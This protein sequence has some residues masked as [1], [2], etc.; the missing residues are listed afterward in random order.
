MGEDQNQIGEL[1]E[2]RLVALLQG[3]GW[4]FWGENRD[5]PCTIRNHQDT[6]SHGVDAYMSYEDPYLKNQRGIL[7][8]S[9]SKQWSSW[10]GGSLSDSADQALE[11]LE[12]VP[13]SDKFHEVFNGPNAQTIN[14]AILG[15]YTNQGNYSREKV[16][17]YTN[18]L[19]IKKKGRG[20]FNVII[21][22]NYD[23][24]RL[25]S[26]HAEF[27]N[28]KQQFDGENNSVGF[29]YPSLSDSISE[30][31]HLVSIEYLLSD[32]LFAKLKAVETSRE[33]PKDINVV[34]NF[35]DISHESLSFMLESLKAYQLM[36]G[37]EIWLYYYSSNQDGEDLDA[38]TILKGFIQN[39]IPEKAP[40]FEINQMPKVEYKSYV[41]RARDSH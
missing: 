1:A 20:Q 2:D 3:L 34:F 33:K 27:I 16:S 40:R 35:E 29:Y 24:N 6:E 28:I 15:A 37:D 19:E 32:F 11:T 9:K 38:K 21:L 31:T 41:D 5:I 36:D 13:N 26:L 39:E 7:V 10:N 30:R 23:L 22:D 8:E 25:A 4:E 17:E 18:D 12:C 14:T